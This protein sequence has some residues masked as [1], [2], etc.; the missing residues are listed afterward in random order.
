MKPVS[1]VR[2]QLLQSSLQVKFKGGTQKKSP[3]IFSN[4]LQ[5]FIIYISVFKW[6]ISKG[7]IHQSYWAFF[8]FNSLLIHVFYEYVVGILFDL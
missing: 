4:C 8:P 7:N 1:P 6:S 2:A 3:H 5:T